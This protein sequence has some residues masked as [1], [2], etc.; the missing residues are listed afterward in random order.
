[1]IKPIEKDVEQLQKQFNYIKNTDKYGS[2]TE[3]DQESKSEVLEVL[4]DNEFNKIYEDLKDN[5][6]T[7]ELN[8]EKLAFIDGSLE[9]THN[10]INEVKRSCEIRYF[11]RN[12]YTLS[13]KKL[14]EGYSG[15]VKELHPNFNVERLCELYERPP[16][17]LKTYYNKEMILVDTF[18][19][20]KYVLAIIQMIYNHM[21]LV[22]AL[23]GPEG[24]GKSTK[25][26]QDMF[27]VWWILTEIGVIDYKFNI[28]DMFF[29]SL[30]KLR[31]TEDK[32]FDQ[33]Y[34]IL[35][36]DEGN[37]LNRQNWKDDEVNMF[38]QKLRR[39]RYNKR[40]KFICIPVLGEM[41]TNIVL[42]R[43]NFIF[44][45]ALGN[46]IESGTL[47]KGLVNFYIIPRAKRIYSPHKKTELSS[48]FIKTVLEEN[49]KDKAYLKGVPKEIIVKRIKANGV[50]GFPERE[51]IKELKETNATFTINKQISITEN[52][53][54]CL[55][56]AKIKP[57]NNGIAN[58]D[59]RYYPIHNLL[60]RVEK[61]W[62]NNLELLKKYDEK[63][64]MKEIE[65]GI[66]KSSN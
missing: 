56:R 9:V 4:K 44:E 22:V 3:I 32:Y 17:E 13:K 18:V 28:K 19:F 15:K 63:K 47:T 14:E 49:L 7:H 52:E 6:I 35:A 16:E 25:C 34:R 60:K 24:S 48:H 27:I 26:S 42:S 2:S 54:Y 33:P 66:N 38:F 40:I 29:N 20:R 45:M 23:T 10:K 11:L 58:K 8:Y 31:A 64:N 46:N 39:E 12:G 36:L 51:Y 5:K 37:E 57:K 41:I 61:F 30:H 62:E 53:S 50:W 55:Y 43:V 1:M 21:D 59:F 65:N